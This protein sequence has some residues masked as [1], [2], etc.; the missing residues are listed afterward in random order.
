[1]IKK[2]LVINFLIL[3]GFFSSFAQK[4]ELGVKGGGNIA[5]QNLKNITGIESVTGFH[6]GGFIYFKIPVLP[7]LQIEAQ[8]SQQGI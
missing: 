4:L 2:I 3:F 1:M 6:L 5:T 7:G 8:Y